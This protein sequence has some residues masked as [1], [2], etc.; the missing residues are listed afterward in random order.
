MERQTDPNLQDPS[1][2]S[3]GSKKPKQAEFLEVNKK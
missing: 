2:H 3:Q 1:S